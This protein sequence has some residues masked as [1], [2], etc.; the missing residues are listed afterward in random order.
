MNNNFSKVQQYE[1][2]NL[3]YAKMVKRLQYM[4]VARYDRY[5]GPCTFVRSILAQEHILYGGKV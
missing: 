5:L 2:N 1:K 3:I 4:L